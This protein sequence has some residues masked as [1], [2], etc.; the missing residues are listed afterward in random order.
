M[1]EIRRL[2]ALRAG[3]RSKAEQYESIAEEV[4][5]KDSGLAAFARGLRLAASDV[6]DVITKLLAEMQKEPA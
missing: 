6:T 2:M 3:L 4:N 5:P 1:D